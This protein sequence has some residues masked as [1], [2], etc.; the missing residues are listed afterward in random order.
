MQRD[1]AEPDEMR[2]FS[3]EEYVEAHVAI[4]SREEAVRFVD[5]VLCASEPAEAA[6]LHGH[7]ADDTMN[8][9]SLLSRDCAERVRAL[10]AETPEQ[11]RN[12][13]TEFLRRTG[14]RTRW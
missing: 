12:R 10:R 3:R 6:G 2:A 9:L 11:A 1:S 4:M 13:I 5:E 8:L 7:L 14:L